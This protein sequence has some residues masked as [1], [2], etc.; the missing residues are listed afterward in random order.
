[1]YYGMDIP[2]NAHQIETVAQTSA[3]EYLFSL[4]SEILIPN[5]FLKSVEILSN[6]AGTINIDVTKFNFNFKNFLNILF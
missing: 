6:S 1:M 2:S 5:G 4:N 3:S